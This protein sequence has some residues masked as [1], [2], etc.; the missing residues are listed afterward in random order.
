MY[1]CLAFQR[2]KYV[3]LHGGFVKFHTP[4]G[5]DLYYFEVLLIWLL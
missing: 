2:Q 4:V 3:L 5:I 1:F